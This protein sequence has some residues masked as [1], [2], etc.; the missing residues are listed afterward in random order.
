MEAAG[1]KSFTENPFWR[2]ATYFS[3]LQ[4]RQAEATRLPTI[5][6]ITP[7]YTRL[8]QKAELTRM[9]S[10]LLHIQALHWIVVEDSVNKTALVS[11]F[12]VKSGLPF[13]H[14]AVKTPPNVTKSRGALQRNLGLKWLRDKYGAS[15]PAEGVVHFADDDNT[16]SLDIFQEMRDTKM[17]SVWPVAFVGGLR[18]ESIDL[19]SSGKV[20][21]WKVKYD[22]GRPFAIDMAGFAVKL[23]LI[24]EKQQAWFNPYAKGGY[25]ESSLLEDLVMLEELEPRA[26][27]CTKILVWHTRTEHPSTGLDRGFTDLA[28]EV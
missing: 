2:F 23:D 13:T 26:D 3:A 20:R 27:N 25:Q 11:S 28:V 8:E 18:Y 7:T 22:P 4:I 5:F 1:C 16:Y 21:A 12:L 15:R 19:D 24:L 6:T 17:V 9:A 14:L 10:T